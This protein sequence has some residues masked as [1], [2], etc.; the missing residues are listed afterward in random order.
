MSCVLYGFTGSV[1]HR[2]AR[3]C[4]IEKGVKHEHREVNPFLPEAHPGYEKLHP[5]WKVPVLLDGEFK[6]YETLA[7]T[8]YVDEKFPG[9]DLQ[10][11]PVTERARMM[12]IISMVD[13]YGYWPMVRQVFSNRV[14]APLMGEEVSETE[15]ELGVKKS[16]LFLAALEPL[17]S[18]KEFLCGAN[19]CLAD[20]HLAPMIDYFQQAPEGAELLSKFEKLSSWWDSTRQRESMVSTDPWLNSG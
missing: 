10:P 17:V 1:Y 15:I 7:I 13:A 6:L 20:I 9:P 4:L 8:R 19:L 18:E 14:Y 16:A 2:V 5:F 11:T 3:V 12:Q